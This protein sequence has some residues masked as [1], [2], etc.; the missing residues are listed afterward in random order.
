[1]RNSRQRA[2]T[3]LP[4][5][6]FVIL[7][8]SGC[9]LMTPDPATTPAPPTA[10]PTPSPAPSATP[11]PEPGIVVWLEGG[12]L[13]D[14]GGS[15]ATVLEELAL[16]SGLAFV[17]IPLGNPEALPSGTEIIASLTSADQL[18]PYAERFPQARLIGLLEPGADV[19]AGLTPLRL[20][21]TIDVRAAFLAGYTTA[22]LA[23]NYR[24]SAVVASAEIGRAF[25][26][27]GRYYC[28]LCRPL[29]PPFDDYPLA[30]QIAGQLDAAGVAEVATTL[31]S[32]RVSYVYMAPDTHSS[33]LAQALAA[34]GMAVL[35]HEKPEGIADEFWVAAIRPAPEVALEQAW[36]IMMEEGKLAGA[37]IPLSIVQRNANLLSAA[38]LRVVEEVQRDLAR[39]Y[40]RPGS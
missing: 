23:P 20:D 10:H 15:T 26:N 35:A 36:R 9:G 13:A 31:S 29:D 19:P 3:L 24:A 8:L 21:P 37:T 16:G 5:L 28:G 6:L 11:T 27:G 30:F 17:S 14:V 34:E 39:G 33:A 7:L 18:V 40:L 22:L 38:R 1:M 4:L 32:S 2:R 25:R 12:E